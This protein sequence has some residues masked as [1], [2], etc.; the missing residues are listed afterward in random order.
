[1][2]PETQTREIGDD[3]KA[4]I[5]DVLNRRYRTTLPVEMV[6]SAVAA[7]FTSWA[8]LQDEANSMQDKDIQP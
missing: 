6:E 5:V 8:L 3:G 7:G 1:M 2:T 4:R